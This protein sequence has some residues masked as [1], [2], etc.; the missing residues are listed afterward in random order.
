MNTLG[1]H[2]LTKQKKNGNSHLQVFMIINGI[3]KEH[4]PHFKEGGTGEETVTSSLMLR[5]YP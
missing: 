3:F 5:T 1:G 2:T 4:L